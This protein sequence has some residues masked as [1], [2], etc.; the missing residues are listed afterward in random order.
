MKIED[1]GSTLDFDKGDNALVKLQNLELDE[2]EYD[3]STYK[4]LALVFEAVNED[5]HS[6]K[7]TLPFWPSS[8]ITIADTEEMSS[9][10][11]KMLVASEQTEDVVSKLIDN[12]EMV[13]AVVSGDKRLEAES[14]ED[15]EALGKALASALKDK[16]FRV[17]VT[18]KS[19]KNGDYWKIK[20]FYKEVDED[21]FDQSSQ[22][23]SS[24][25]SEESEESED[26]DVLDGVEEPDSSDSEY[27]G[28]SK[29]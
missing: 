23:T 24:E 25:E 17:G 8:R 6:V 29:A 22:E 9:A 15:N 19:G 4:K 20:E 2:G 7:G 1:M 12:P 13:N 10:L 11:G 21:P 18:K 14:D 3:G 5:D 26:E 16:V 28:G 27:V